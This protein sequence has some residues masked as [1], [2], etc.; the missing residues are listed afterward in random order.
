MWARR[1]LGGAKPQGYVFRRYNST[2]SG[3]SGGVLALAR[4]RKGLTALTVGSGA[5]VTLYYTNDTFALGA[6]H[7]KHAFQRIVTVAVACTKCFS[8][9]RKTLKGS[10]ESEEEYQKALS[11]THTNAAEITRLAIEKNA[12]VFI[13]LGQHIAALT[14]IFPEEWTSAMI[15]LQDQCPTSSYEEIE[16]LIR[17]DV[18]G[19]VDD[20]FA[21]FEKEPLGTASLAQ[22][23]KATLKDSGMEVA[24]KVQH[25][26]L[27]EFVPLDV[28]MTK[29]VF[30]LIDFFFKDY[31]LTWLS[32]ELQS[33]IFVELDFTEEA[34]N[35]Q[36]TQE[37]FRDF[38]NETAL[39]VPDVVWA[40]PRILVMEF[41]RGARLDDL[42]FY[43]KHHISR[44]EV[45]SCLSH[46]FNNMIFTPNV[47][48]HCDPHPGN[49]AIIPRKRHLLDGG[50]NFEIILYDHGLYR[51]VPT[52][53][54]R[55]YA[56]FWLAL[57][58]GDEPKMRKY[59]HDFAGIDEHNFQ[60]FAA[61]ITGRDFEN[62]TSNV[63]SRRTENEKKH[64]SST[65]AEEGLLSNIMV[66]LHS[67]PRIV[68]LILKTNDLTRYLDEK[69]DAPLGTERTFLIM[70]MYCAR[71]VY[72]EERE[73]IYSKYKYMW[74][75]PRILAE[76]KNWWGFFC[77]RS[78]LTIY[79]IGMII[80]NVLPLKK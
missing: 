3:G 56:R 21:T 24:V 14:Y 73:R 6:R 10:Y 58:D 80:S 54:R 79:D 2:A 66:L 63:M 71:T 16:G 49:L 61:A 75:V 30:N 77:R 68:L 74:S 23:H 47:G 40:K 18:G 35:A 59:A 43:D 34:K 64:M 22:V 51:Y 7:T 5:F 28:L 55:S 13:K 78:Q 60:L 15:P 72:E 26:S 67:M 37:Y 45:S 69:L 33:S 36:K 38:Y 17:K 4:R 57:L 25:P 53:I 76:I 19:T 8:L 9:Y 50:H 62:A 31:P 46:L 1:I 52:N 20:Y 41:L 12:G 29:T 11:K 32:E 70:A 48:L 65:I 44:N 39:R 42:E 27:E